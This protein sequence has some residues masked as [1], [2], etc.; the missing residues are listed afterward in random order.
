[1]LAVNHV[2]A[3][4]LILASCILNVACSKGTQLKPENAFHSE[5][6]FAE[7]CDLAADLSRWRGDT[8]RTRAFS[9]YGLLRLFGKECL[10]NGSVLVVSSE[11]IGNDEYNRALHGSFVDAR[12]AVEAE[13]TV[14]VIWEEIPVMAA[15]GVI[16]LDATKIRSLEAPSRDKLFDLDD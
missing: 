12:I 8:V 15:R 4:S 5:T 9:V 7:F 2:I 14:Q 10:G 11:I 3:T 16:L 1:M 13:L 6:Q